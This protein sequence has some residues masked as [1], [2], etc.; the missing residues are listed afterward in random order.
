[1]KGLILTLL[2][3]HKLG[4]VRESWDMSD[5]VHGI[6]RNERMTTGKAG[7]GNVSLQ[8]SIAVGL[9]SRGFVTKLG[10]YGFWYSHVQTRNRHVVS[11]I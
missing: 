8:F 9:L 7:N 11:K 10:Q 2:S 1:M 3:V 6:K 5:R 4:R